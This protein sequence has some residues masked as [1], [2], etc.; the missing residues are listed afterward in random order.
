MAKKQ[1]VLVLTE[2]TEGEEN[3]FNRYYEDQHLGE[4]L[5]TTGWKSAQRF[6]LVDQAGCE[7][8]LP[9][10]ALYE[11]E[12]MEGKTAIEVMNESRKDRV[13][14]GAL[15]KKTAAAWVFEEIGPEHE[16]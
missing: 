11:T 13:Q 5:E 9:Y 12:A 3:E 1:I 4:V 8:P 10:L 16:P 2:P 6:K 15:N 7:C 14:S